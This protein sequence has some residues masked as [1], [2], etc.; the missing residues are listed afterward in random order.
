MDFALLSLAGKIQKQ[1]GTAYDK[2][3]NYFSQKI[4][5]CPLLLLDFGECWE[6]L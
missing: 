4:N 1:K 2:T 5:R 3:K 6:K